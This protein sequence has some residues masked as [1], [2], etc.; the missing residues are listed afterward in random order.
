MKNGKFHNTR[1]FQQDSAINNSFS[2]DM[3]LT[4]LCYQLPQMYF[5]ILLLKTLGN[6]CKRI[7]ECKSVLFCCSRMKYE[8][9]VKVIVVNCQLQL[10]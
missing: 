7:G 10:N 6:I 1:G 3:A 9:T 4:S 8:I 2:V 5:T